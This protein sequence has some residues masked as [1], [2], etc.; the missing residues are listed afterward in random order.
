MSDS[1]SSLC[2]SPPHDQYR[3]RFYNASPKIRG[4]SATKFWGQKHA[5]FGAILHNFQIWSRISPEE[6]RYQKS[7]RHAIGNNSSRVRWNKSRELWST[8]HKVVHVSLDPPKSIFSGDDIS[9]A[10]VLAPAIFTRAK[11]W[12]T[13]AS[14]HHKPGRGPQKF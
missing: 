1:P 14:A 4:P 11:N 10:R 2:R 6:T 8:I 13:L 3:R 12:P 9:A 5:K 7:E